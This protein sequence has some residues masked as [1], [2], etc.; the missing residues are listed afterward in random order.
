MSSRFLAAFVCGSIGFTIAA[1]PPP[2]YVRIPSGNLSFEVPG[3][4]YAEGTKQTIGENHAR[5]A[6]EGKREAP[7]EIYFAFSLK[8]DTD[9]IISSGPSKFVSGEEFERMDIAAKGRE[10]EA[11][12]PTANAKAGYKIISWYS[13]QKVKIAGRNAFKYEYLRSQ[14]RGPNTGST[15]KVVELYIYES[16]AMNYYF[17]ASY[18]PTFEKEMRPQVD[19]ILASFR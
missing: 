7:R 8:Y 6:A 11:Q 4:W 2:N 14:P 15:A 19:H 12:F 13:S 9:V 16:P 17:R 3:D 1:E 10:A 18:N 5:I